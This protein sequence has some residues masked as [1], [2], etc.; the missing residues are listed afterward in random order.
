MSVDCD[1]VVVDDA[2]GLGCG[3][4]ERR[5]ATRFMTKSVTWVRSSMPGL[6][7][8]CQYEVRNRWWVVNGQY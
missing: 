2:V 8:S 6:T 7:G 1:W 4:W 3:F 5:A